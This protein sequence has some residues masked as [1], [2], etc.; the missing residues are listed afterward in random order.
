LALLFS[1]LCTRSNVVYC[2][3][4]KRAWQAAVL[5]SSLALPRPHCVP[6]HGQNG[7]KDSTYCPELLDCYTDITRVKSA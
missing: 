5:G 1:S 7:G 4:E 2:P 6:H 3:R